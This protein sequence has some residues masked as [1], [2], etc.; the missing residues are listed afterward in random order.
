MS[1]DVEKFTTYG[2]A[3]YR[4]GNW[5]EARD[6]F[7]VLC[8]NRPLEPQFWVALGACLQEAGSY[9]EA[10]EPWAMAALLMPN[11][12]YPHFHA[13]ECYFSLSQT[14]DAGKALAES[15]AHIS[16]DH[17]LAP[18]INLLKEQWHLTV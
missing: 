6:A 2:V 7:R 4:S 18:K 5:D 9:E 13:A 11:D 14:E 8:S 16:G 1:L 10:L 3:Q 12:P 17:P 15:A